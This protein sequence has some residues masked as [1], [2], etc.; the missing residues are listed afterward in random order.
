MPLSNICVLPVC[1]LAG[2]LLVIPPFNTVSAQSAAVKSTTSAKKA[3]PARTCFNVG[4]TI[5]V[6]GR[7]TPI[8][9]ANFVLYQPRAKGLCAH[10]PK[11]SSHVTL[12]DFDVNVPPGP[13]RNVKLPQGVYLEVTGLLTDL[14]PEISPLGLKVL[15]FRNVDAEVKAELSD[16]TERCK[17][18]QD[19]QLDIISPKLHGGNVGRFTDA[20][21]RTCG[22]EGVNAQLPHEVIG[23]I[24]RREQ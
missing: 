9:G 20:L 3:T 8:I 24:W 11:P 21:N 13:I 4:D 18:W 12:T 14:F 17:E 23:P 1:V 5:T 2:T 19:R 16:W 22:I 10:Y 7:F 15:S 6:I